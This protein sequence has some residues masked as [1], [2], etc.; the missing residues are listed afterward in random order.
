M[1]SRGLSRTYGDE[2]SYSKKSGIIDVMNPDPELAAFAADDE[3]EVDFDIDGSGGL[4]PHTKDA[5]L[6]IF[7]HG[8]V[9]F[10]HSHGVT[11]SVLASDLD[12]EFAA[13]V[14]GVAGI[15]KDQNIHNGSWPGHM[16]RQK[17]KITW[18][19]DLNQVQG[20]SDL[21]NQSLAEA[22]LVHNE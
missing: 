22:W 8:G 21:L 15:M 19:P 5:I 13:W 12:P 18:R 17:G 6:C 14:R 20:H 11:E 7:S 16:T 3:S 9:I 4:I 2:M 1:K 10:K